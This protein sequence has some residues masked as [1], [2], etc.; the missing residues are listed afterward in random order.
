MTEFATPRVFEYTDNCATYR[1]EIE[2]DTDAFRESV[3]KGNG[4]PTA[5]WTLAECLA[6]VGSSDPCAWTEITKPFD[7][8]TLDW[9]GV[10]HVEKK[11]PLASRYFF[12]P[13]TKTCLS[14]VCYE[15]DDVPKS[16]WIEFPR[17]DIANQTIADLRRR[18]AELEG[19]KTIGQKI[20]E[21][22]GDF[23]AELKSESEVRGE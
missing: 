4:Y 13:E 18:V 1:V 15:D 16:P 20:V 8:A 12:D 5:L 2:N 7:P 14:G 23:V 21:R 6:D 9:S 10:G 3:V 19:K 17:P 22:L 11:E